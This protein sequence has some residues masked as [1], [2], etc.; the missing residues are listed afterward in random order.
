MIEKGR[1]RVVSA[2]EIEPELVGMEGLYIGVKTG[3]GR[4]TVFLDGDDMPAYFEEQDLEQIA[5]V[6]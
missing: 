1:V 4:L 6:E 2:D 5:E 3:G